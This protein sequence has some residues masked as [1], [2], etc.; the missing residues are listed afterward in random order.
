MSGDRAIRSIAIAGGGI[1]GLSAAIAFARGLPGISVAIIGDGDDEAAVADRRPVG[2]P[3]VERFHAL[4]GID[5]ADLVRSGAAVHHLGT[6]FEDW[7]EGHAWVHAFGPYGK[8]A[9][10]VHFDQVWWR[11][12]DAGDALAHDRYSV[13]AA[14]AR[15]GKFV[16]PAEDPQSLGSRFQYGLRFDPELYREWLAREAA[17]LGVA[18]VRGELGEVE[19]GE[20]GISAL[21][22]EGGKRVEADLFV[23]CSGPSGRL[24]CAI[25]DSF[26]D[27]SGWMPFD[28][29]SLSSKRSEVTATA[30]RVSS[31]QAS[32]S[33]EGWLGERTLRAEMSIGGEGVAIARGRRLRPWTHNV[34]GLGDSATALDPLHGL[35]LDLA[36]RAILLAL[37]LL[38]GRSFSPLETQEYNRR[39][40]LITRRVRDFVAL[41]YLHWV[42]TDLPD[43]LARTLDQYRYRARLPFHED[44]SIT[45]DSWTAALIGL[46]ILP[47]NAEPHAVGVPLDKAAQA[48]RRIAREIEETVP[49]VPSYADYVANLR[50]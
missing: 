39:A 46:G 34:L 42:R 3:G 27:W 10:G 24:I 28:R 18:T 26:E 22:L 32:W 9:G 36:Q 43:S 23:D 25:D 11:M 38:P 31:A 33:M 29:L 21:L 7:P 47:E 48:M 20:D 15:A 8:P 5:E 13:G 12:R 14:L 37:E 41:H 16:H 19:R 4:L 45:R 2:W 49:Q 40:E 1:V 17:S 35:N 44:E 6:I 50:R 30:D